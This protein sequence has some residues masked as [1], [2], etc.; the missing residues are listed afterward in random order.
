MSILYVLL[1]IWQ[2]ISE[3]ITALPLKQTGNFIFFTLSRDLLF[4]HVPLLLFPVLSVIVSMRETLALFHDVIVVLDEH[5]D[6]RR[7]QKETINWSFS[8]ALA[9][10]SISAL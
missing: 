2:N 7:R 3:S 5:H 1:Y 4:C 8:V 6:L 9:G 10:C